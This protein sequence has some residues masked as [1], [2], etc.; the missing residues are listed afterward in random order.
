MNGERAVLYSF[1]N[2]NKYNGTLFYCFEYYCFAK[3]I[4]SA[5]EFLI[6]NINPQE[7]EEVKAVFSNKYQFDESYLKDIRAVESIKELYDLTL[8]SSLI[9]DIHT[10]NQIYFFLRSDIYCYSNVAHEMKRSEFKKIKYFG[11]YDYQNFDFDVKLKLNFEIFKPIT[12]TNIDGIFVSSRKDNYDDFSLPESLKH[13]RQIN[14]DKNSHYD[15]LYEHFDTVYYYHSDLDTNNR[16]IPECFYYNKKIHIEFNGN[17]KDSIF[18]RFDDI[19]KNGL[20]P[21]SLDE[22]DVMLRSFLGMEG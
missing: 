16:L 2:Y 3:K 18:L 5:V 4:D 14:K 12:K 22:N 8:K 9:L 10:F 1:K 7:L 19:S 21:Y 11:H 20:K 6:F 15:N 17:Y 13:L